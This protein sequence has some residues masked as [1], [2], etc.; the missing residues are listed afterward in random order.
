MKIKNLLV[1]TAILINS[2]QISSCKKETE[3][4]EP[5]SCEINKTGTIGFNLSGKI[6]LDPV[7]VF[8]NG[9]FVDSLFVYAMNDNEK[10]NIT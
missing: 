9:E 7:N 8:V 2:A 6:S 3:E 5:K 10:D 1:L 4:T